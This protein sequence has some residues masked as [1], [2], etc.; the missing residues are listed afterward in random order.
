MSVVERR[1]GGTR[2]RCR[3]EEEDV[4]LNTAMSGA[5]LARTKAAVDTFNKT[6]AD[7]KVKGGGLDKDDFLKIL[8]TQLQHQD[9]TAPLED[10]EF[11]AQMAQFSSLEQMTNMSQNF[12]RL[13]GL[14]TSS[15]AAQYLGKNVLIQDGDA[16]VRGQVSEV[17]RGDT[18]LVG[19]N[20]KYYDFNQISSV[21][22]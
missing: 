10:K 6:L 9:P 21:I 4:E 2:R 19:V 7:G 18:P 15:E 14:L 3:F 22:Q 13:Q 17:V 16:V 5:D 12:Q 1:A 8:V 20:G 11:I